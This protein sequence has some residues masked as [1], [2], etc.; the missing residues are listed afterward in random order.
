MSRAFTDVI[1]DVN[2]GFTAEE[3]TEAVASAVRAVDQTG[4]PAEITLKLK[5]RKGPRGTGAVQ[6]SANVGLKL[7]KEDEQVTLMYGTPEGSLLRDDPR[8]SKLDLKVAPGSSQAGPLAQ[9]S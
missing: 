8:Q 1:R 5:I 2:G 7:P 6:V 9:A 3:L 4:K